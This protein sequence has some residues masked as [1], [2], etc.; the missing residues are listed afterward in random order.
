MIEYV[1]IAIVAF[2]ASLLTFFSGFGL[3]TLLTP[4]FIIFFPVEIAI[5]LTAIVHFLNNLYKLLL[6]GKHMDWS[7]VLRFGIPAI[8]A[9]IAGAYVLN[10]FV[11]QETLFVYELLGITCEMTWI[12]IVIGTLMIMFAILDIAPQLM[13]VK[14]Q[15][16]HLPI[17]GLLSGFFGGLSGHQ[18]ALR[19]AFLIKCGLSKEAF[20]AT[21]IV[22]ACFIDAGR[23]T[24]YFNDLITEHLI[25]HKSILLTAMFSSFAGALLGSKVLKKVS[26]NAVHLIVAILIFCTGAALILGLL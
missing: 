11:E 14:I 6:I 18:G 12:K 13:S 1:L 16:K 26:L 23:I 24:V 7:V 19:S 21:G 22:I 15:K 2:A 20:I 8:F 5:A 10:T 25:T 3:G 4:T 9:A 17:G